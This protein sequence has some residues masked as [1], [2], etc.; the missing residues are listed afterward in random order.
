MKKTLLILLFPFIVTAQTQIGEDISPNEGFEGAGW[1]VSLSSD[2][3]TIATGGSP[4]NLQGNMFSRARVYNYDGNNWIQK[5]QNL[6]IDEFSSG[7]LYP[8]SRVSLSSDG[9]ALAMSSPHFGAEG[10]AGKAKIYQYD[11]TSWQQKG[12]DFTGEIDDNLG[13]SITLSA[14]G[15]IVAILTSGNDSP[16]NMGDVTIY[17]YNGSQWQQLGQKIIGVY[18]NDTNFFNMFKGSISL[19]TDGNTI[20]IGTPFSFNDISSNAGG[21]VRVYQYNGTQWQE[22]GQIINNNEGNKFGW[23]VSLS[24]DGNFVAISRMD[25]E[26]GAAKVYQFTD[27]QWIQKG[28]DI[29][30]EDADNLFGYSIALSSN[31]NVLVVGTPVSG[32]GGHVKIYKYIGNEWVQAGVDI[33]SSEISYLGADVSLTPQAD[34]L[35]IGLPLLTQDG[36]TR[37]YELGDILSSDTFVQANFS[38]YP[39]PTQKFLNIELKDNLG[40][41]NVNIYNVSGQLIRKAETSSIDVS[42]LSAGT[43]YIQVITD[44][45]KATKAFIKK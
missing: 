1:F 36:I 33:N 11:G 27:G 13:Y 38:I 2:G 40:F 37:V 26:L 23:D 45:G 34:F 44:Q 15:N 10:P 30:G 8:R 16:D 41:V 22:R 18:N 3:Q 9:N 17:Q 43:Y 12:Q 39:N 35:A 5:G 20:A 24:G 25:N 31:G 32:A 4:R 19:S 6:D 21:Q 14:D 28:Q 29:V 7:N 42:D